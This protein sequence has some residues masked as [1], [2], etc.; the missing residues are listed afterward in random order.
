[1]YYFATFIHV[2]NIFAYKRWN[3]F[4]FETFAYFAIG[5]ISNV[6]DISAI[7]ITSISSFILTRTL[8]MLFLQ[9]SCC[10]NP[11]CLRYCLISN[12]SFR[13]II[14]EYILPS[15]DPMV[16]GLQFSTSSALFPGLGKVYSVVGFIFHCAGY[17]RCSM[18]RLHNFT[19]TCSVLFFKVDFLSIVSDLIFLNFSIRFLQC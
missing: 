16:I 19:N 12:Y 11:F 10:V 9:S 6:F 5:T 7:I 17:I 3:F 14:A 1:M 15:R 18:R 4:D 13:S 2:L 8:K